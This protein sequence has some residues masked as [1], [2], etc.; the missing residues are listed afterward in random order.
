[1]Q[2]LTQERAGL[3][4]RLH[5]GGA[6]WRSRR[7]RRLLGRCL[8]G[9]RLKHTFQ[10]FVIIGLW[11]ISAN[12]SSFVT[13]FELTHR[14]ESITTNAKPSRIAW[15]MAGPHYNSQNRNHPENPGRT[16]KGRNT[17]STKST[18]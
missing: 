5:S 16:K 12:E 6:E 9:Q 1:M 8:I 13:F 10:G 17:K 7:H 2:K 4:G 18:K 15:L 3:G 14:G 11:C